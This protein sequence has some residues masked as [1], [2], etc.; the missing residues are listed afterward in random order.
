MSS[1]LKRVIVTQSSCH[2]CGVDA[3]EVYHQHFPEMRIS[4][5]SALQAAERL[6]AHLESEL[7]AVSDPLHRNPVQFA[8]A[9]V[10]AFLCEQQAKHPS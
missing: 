3:V 10:Q 8:I 6:C 4:G 9:D 5:N 1:D 7:D 2:H